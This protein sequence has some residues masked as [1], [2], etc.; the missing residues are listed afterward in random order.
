MCLCTYRLHVRLQRLWHFQALRS[1]LFFLVEAEIVV[2]LHFLFWRSIRRDEWRRKVEGD[3]ENSDLTDRRGRQEIV[4]QNTLFFFFFSP[5][6]CFCL[7]LSK[8][9]YC[10]LLGILCQWF[11]KWWTPLCHLNQTCLKWTE[12]RKK[13][14]LIFQIFVSLGQQ[15]DCDSGRRCIFVYLLSGAIW[16]SVFSVWPCL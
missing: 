4:C 15:L 8:T 12:L 7:F 14:F 13:L 11:F 3:G 10:P 6:C 1:F 16:N 5:F 9:D 2:P